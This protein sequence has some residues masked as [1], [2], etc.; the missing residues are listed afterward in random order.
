MLRQL[1]EI[2]AKAASKYRA[3]RLTVGALLLPCAF[4]L[5]ASEAGLQQLPDSTAG[6]D[7][8]EYVAPEA[9]TD[10]IM[11]A[12]PGVALNDIYLVKHTRD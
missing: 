1:N 7:I 12:L 5:A 8:T 11:A 3:L 2:A 4:T 9:T 6:T 10:T